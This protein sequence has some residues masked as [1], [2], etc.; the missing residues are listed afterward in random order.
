MPPAAYCPAHGVALDPQQDV[1]LRTARTLSLSHRV[2][3]AGF[4]LAGAFD[5]DERAELK[6][7]V[8]HHIAHGA[9]GLVVAP[10]PFT[11]PSVSEAVI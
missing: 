3:R 1:I 7:V 5:G 10:A 8:L 4:H 11:M 2:R 9:G 6:Q